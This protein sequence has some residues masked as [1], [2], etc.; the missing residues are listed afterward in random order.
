MK[1]FF[2][3]FKKFIS[4]GNVLDLAIG[5]IIGAAF[6]AIV[7]SLVND[8]L[9]P[10]I[11]FFF[12]QGDLNDQF[13]VL[14]GTASYI[15]NP[16]TGVLE[17]VK[18]EN[19]VLLYWGRFFQSIIDFLIIGLTL[20]IIVKVA[21]SVQKKAETRKQAI[22]AKLLKKQGIVEPV[23]PEEEEEEEV[24]EEILLLREIRDS[25]KVNKE[26]KA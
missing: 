21:I 7:K 11:G 15:P 20:F 23:E 6:N 16:V 18:S 24:S 19:A 22:K 1:K 12:G 13:F 8:V 4:K 26:E 25:L 2:A 5:M 10:T 3:D 9:M 17:L 14:R